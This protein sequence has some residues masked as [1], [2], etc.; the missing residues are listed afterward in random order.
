MSRSIRSRSFFRRNR[1]IS[2][3]WSAVETGNGLSDGAVAGRAAIAAAAPFG[4]SYRLTQRD[5]S[6]W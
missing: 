6:V 5:S 1:A 4:C 2:D 3:A